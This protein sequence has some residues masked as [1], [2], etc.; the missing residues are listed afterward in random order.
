MGQRP[1]AVH[2]DRRRAIGGCRRSTAGNS[3][4]ARAESADPLENNRESADRSEAAFVRNP[5]KREVPVGHQLFGAI[6][7]TSKQ[8]LARRNANR[9]FELWQK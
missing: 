4:I 6:D 5:G 2:F 3:V 1:V 7:A 9:L 8:V